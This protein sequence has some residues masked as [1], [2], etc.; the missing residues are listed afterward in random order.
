MKIGPKKYYMRQLVLNFIGIDGQMRLKDAKVA[1]VGVGGLGCNVAVQLARTGIGH[2]KIIDYDYVEPDNLHRQ[3]LYLPKDIGKLKAPIAA[4]R[5]AEVNPNIKVE[6]I[7]EKL[8]ENNVRDLLDDVNLIID[9]LDN[10]ATRYIINKYAVKHG[11]PYIFSGVIGLEGNITIINPPDTPCLECVFGGL[12]DEE[13]PKAS[14]VGI[15]PQIPAILGA[16]EAVEA[17]KILIGSSSPLRG[18]L[19]SVDLIDLSFDMVEI[20]RAENCPVCSL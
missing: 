14:E 18:K 16:I 3:I 5:L 15:L 17:I 10:M 8:H 11:I 1:I 20:K 19:L 6:G 12:R 4:K 9:G 13:L 2:I 7:A